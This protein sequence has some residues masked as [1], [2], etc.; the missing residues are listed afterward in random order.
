MRKP[1]A[2]ALF[3]AALAV[4]VV[5]API[6]AAAQTFDPNTGALVSP[7]APQPFATFT[8]QPGQVLNGLGDSCLPSPSIPPTHPSLLGSVPGDLSITPLPPRPL[9]FNGTNCPS[10]QVLQANGE[11][12]GPPTPARR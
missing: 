2:A 1:L 10:G 9:F 8:C 7:T 5:A 12:C 3:A 6:A 4:A 11:R